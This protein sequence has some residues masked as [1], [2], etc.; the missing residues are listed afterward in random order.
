[1][2][3]FDVEKRSHLK[4]E[5]LLSNATQKGARVVLGGKRDPQSTC[6]KPTLLINVT[7]DMDIAHTE[8]FGPVIAI[9]KFE[10]EEEVLALA[11]HCRTGLAGYIFTTDYAQ[12]LRVSRSLQV[13]IIGVNEGMVSCAEAA[14]G[15]IKES[16]LGREGGSQGIDEFSQWKYVCVGF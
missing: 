1:M 9:Q 16:G 7:N 2:G 10:T 13:G 11:N 6:F 14:F 8:I 4:V 5:Q 15:G 3:F 12:I